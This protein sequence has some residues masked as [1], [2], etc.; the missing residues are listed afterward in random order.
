MFGNAASFNQELAAWNV[1][2]GKS[3]IVLD[4]LLHAH[5]VRNS[6]AN[7]FHFLRSVELQ[8]GLVSMGYIKR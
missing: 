6:D 2:K 4:N 3:S 1:S 7:E 5:Q 8:S